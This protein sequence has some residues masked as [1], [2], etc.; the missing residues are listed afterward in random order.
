MEF[1]PVRYVLPK[2]IPEGVAAR[3]PGRPKI[4]KSWL[5]LDLCLAAAAE[6]YFAGIKPRGGDVLYLALEDGKRRLKRRIDK[7][8]PLFS[9]EWPDG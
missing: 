8:V 4:E 1:E 2:F 9:G 7:L 5:V 3:L 6:T